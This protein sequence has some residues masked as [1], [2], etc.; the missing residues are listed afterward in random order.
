M[1]MRNEES[2]EERDDSGEEEASIQDRSITIFYFNSTSLCDESFSRTLRKKSSQLFQGQDG[3]TRSR[4]E[5]PRA[6]G[7]GSDTEGPMADTQRSDKVEVP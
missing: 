7:V 4:S 6:A 2:G 3:V 1:P 5:R